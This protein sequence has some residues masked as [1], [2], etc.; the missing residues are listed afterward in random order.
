MT[1]EVI[2]IS[3]VMGFRHTTGW[4]CVQGGKGGVKVLYWFVLCAAGVLRFDLCRV[5]TGIYMSDACSPDVPPDILYPSSLRI[6]G[7]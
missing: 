6:N 2:Y 4:G 3:T 7:R 5:Y 1:P